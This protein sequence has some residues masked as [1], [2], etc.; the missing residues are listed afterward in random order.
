MMLDIPFSNNQ[1]NYIVNENHKRSDIITGYDK[2]EIKDKYMSLEQDIYTIIDT[3]NPLRLSTCFVRQNFLHEQFKNHYNFYLSKLRYD[4]YNSLKNSITVYNTLVNSD[5]VHYLFNNCKTYFYTISPYH[6]TIYDM[7]ALNFSALK[8]MNRNISYTKRLNS[9]RGYLIKYEL[10][11]SVLKGKP[12]LNP[13]CHILYFIDDKNDM[14]I[15]NNIDDYYTS[16]YM[17]YSDTKF[18]LVKQNDDDF[19]KLMSYIS[20]D[21][22]TKLFHSDK[23]I[24]PSN[25]DIIAQL[26]LLRNFR[27]ISVYKELK[28]IFKNGDDVK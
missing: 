24:K 10:S 18:Q 15:M 20:K 21:V 22:Y 17:N 25:T 19:Q 28:N 1:L 4:T 9:V 14:D 23:S 16:Y 7:T 3:D 11:W 8:T 26:A 2:Q 6:N 27:F 13:H 12:C 5:T